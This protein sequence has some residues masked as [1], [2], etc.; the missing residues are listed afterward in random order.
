MTHFY[1]YICFIL[2][3][4]FF[5]IFLFYDLRYRKIPLRLSK[6]CLTIAITLNVFEYFLFF[7]HFY[8]FF[9]NKI[10]IVLI[11]LFLSLILF[12]LKILGGSDGK[13]LLFIFIVHPLLFLNISIIFTFFFIF[14]LLF[15]LIFVSN[16]INNKR[17]QRNFSFLIY[18]YSNLK[19]TCIKRFFIKTFYK[20]INYSKLGEYN[21]NKSLIK[22]LDLVYNIELNKIQMMCQIR[23]PLIVIVMLSYY[24]IIY[25]ILI[26]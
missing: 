15:I 3:N 21:E 6:F 19:I 14:S 16:L 20:F 8:I 18:Y 5:L 11:V 13:L 7:K 24:V 25:L 4:G 26:I 12:I 17:P 23:P 10:T 2:L 22:S 9:F 1:L